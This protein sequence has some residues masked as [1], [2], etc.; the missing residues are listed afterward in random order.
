MPHLSRSLIAGLV[1]LHAA[2]ALLLAQPVENR[3]PQP[4]DVTPRGPLTLEEQATISTFEQVAA[5]VV[6]IDTA[7]IVQRRTFFGPTREQIEGTGSGFIWDAEGHVVTNFHVVEGYRSYQ[8]FLADGSVYDA[9]LV[10]V[11]PDE[12]LAVLRIDVEGKALSPIPIGT[13]DD[14]RIGQKVLAIGNPFGLDQTLTTGVVSALG[15]TI[16]SRSNN[17]IDGVI[18]TDAAINPGNSGGPLLDSAGRLIGVNTAIRSPTRASAGIGFAVPVDT[19]ND[20]V[21]ELIAFGEKLTPVLGIRTY[22]TDWRRTLG[23]ARGVLIAGIEPDG[24]ADKAG[25]RP[26]QELRGQRI[27]PGDLILA[28]N[29]TRVDS[30]RELRLVLSRSEAGDTVMLSVYRDDDVIELEAQVAAPRRR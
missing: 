23:F 18:Q 25:L 1:G 27:V 24:P 6:Y 20:I 29:G 5:S 17:E 26:S 3:A 22:P 9:E 8:V 12:D 14:L 10:G 11:A 21:P 28:I 19:V 16:M 7:A 2:A 15:R 4:R 30:L 13:S